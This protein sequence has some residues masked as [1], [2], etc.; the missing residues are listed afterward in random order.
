M[1]EPE[2]EENELSSI[3][4][5]QSQIRELIN[6]IKEFEKKYDEYSYEEPKLEFIEVKDDVVEFVEIEP[7]P[8]DSFAEVEPESKSR[9]GF[10][11]KSEVKKIKSEGDL[12]ELNEDIEPATFRI[13]LNDEG[14]L[15]NIDLNRPEPKKT[16]V[17]NEESEEES[18]ASGLGRIFSRLRRAIP[19]KEETSEES[20]E[21]E[22]EEEY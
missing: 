13:R 8:T 10:R 20:E 21:D 17:K 9:F 18:K 16:K 4:K 19:Q 14:D 12:S 22:E 6:E 7:E 1:D 15:V 3:E 2:L 5:A 11:R